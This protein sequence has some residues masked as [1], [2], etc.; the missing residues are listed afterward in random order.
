MASIHSSGMIKRLSRRTGTGR[1]EAR[2]L[3]H[4]LEDAIQEE[5]AAGNRVV[6]RGFGSFD[7]R[8]YGPGV[9][10]GRTYPAR[11]VP[12]FRAGAEFKRAVNGEG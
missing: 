9:I 5:V 12:R 3:L 8:T 2:R 7:A 4:N 1:E 6:L 11:Q 10:R